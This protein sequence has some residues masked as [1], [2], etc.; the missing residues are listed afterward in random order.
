MQ[1]TID[2]TGY[3]IVTGTYALCVAAAGFFYLRSAKRK[4]EDT[5][6]LYRHAEK[7]LERVQRIV[8]GTEQYVEDATALHETIK[9]AEYVKDMDTDSSFYEF[10]PQAARDALSKF[11]AGRINMLTER[12]T[13]NEQA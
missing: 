9:R 8:I 13:A 5:A 1:M 10:V 12:M 11:Y 3:L 4:L 2:I 6:L 7:E